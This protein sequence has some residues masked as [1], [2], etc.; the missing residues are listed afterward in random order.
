MGRLVYFYSK[1]YQKQKEKKNKSYV[2]LHSHHPLSGATQPPFTFRLKK[3]EAKELETE[4]L[5]FRFRM[6]PRLAGISPG[7][8]Y[9]TSKFLSCQ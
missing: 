5:S 2:L 9:Y 6:R 1:C 3:G 7:K 4:E 8:V